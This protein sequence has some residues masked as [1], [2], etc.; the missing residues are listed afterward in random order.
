MV[1]NGLNDK[2]AVVET[3]GGKVDHVLDDL[4][5]WLFLGLKIL[6]GYRLLFVCW[7]DPNHLLH[8]VS[9]IPPLLCNH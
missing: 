4:L 6:F 9:K 8:L 1:L 2:F 7:P 5:G 3:E